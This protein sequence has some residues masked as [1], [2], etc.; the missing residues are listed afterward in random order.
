MAHTSYSPVRLIGRYRKHKIVLQVLPGNGA[1]EPLRL[2]VHQKPDE[3]GVWQAPNI[4][5]NRH[6]DALLSE[7]QALQIGTALI[8][9]SQSAKRMNTDY[10]STRKR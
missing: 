1:K 7:D 2:T 3:H 5:F 4:F 10:T 9:A 6:L 8:M